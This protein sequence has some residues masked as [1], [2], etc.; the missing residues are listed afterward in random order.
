MSESNQEFFLNIVYKNKTVK[1]RVANPDAPLSALMNNLR[2]AIGG[3][4]K[5]IFDFPSIDSTGAPIDYF[6]AKEDS[7]VHEL[8]VMRP[9][10]GKTDQTLADYN[11]KS[12]DIVSLI[13]DPFPG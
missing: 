6:F 10:I 9:C 13:P 11:V 3:D 4:G 8:R 5:L 1:F 2:H 7:S 12:G